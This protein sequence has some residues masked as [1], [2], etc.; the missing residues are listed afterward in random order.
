MGPGTRRRIV[1]QSAGVG[2][3]VAGRFAGLGPCTIQELDVASGEL[4]EV[5]SETG[6]DLLQPRQTEDGTL[7]YIRKPYESGVPEASLLGSLKDAALFPFR[8]TLAVF[9]IISTSSR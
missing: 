5:A 1:F 8:M 9:F 2:R 4:N 7:Y 6:R 3:N